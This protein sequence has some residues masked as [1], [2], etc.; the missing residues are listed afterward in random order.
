M[1]PRI[2]ECSAT[3]D[4]ITIVFTEVIANRQ[5]T[6]FEL[7]S[8]VGTTVDVSGTAWGD[9]TV[10]ITPGSSLTPGDWLFVK[11][12]FP[13][14]VEAEFFTRVNG[15]ES[16]LVDIA[17]SAGTA[18]KAV[19]SIASY[20]L[21]TTEMGVS[22][23]AP[24]A[25]TGAPPGAPLQRVVDDA[26]RTVLGRLPKVND[27]RSVAAALTQSF[28][29]R[30]EGGRT[31]WEWT[32]KSYVGQTDL[33]GG[34]TGAQAS[35]AA[36]AK[37]ALDNSLP[38]L[39]G[40]SP[41]DSHA[42]PQE[43][44]AA[45]A[46]LRTQWIGFANELANEGGPRAARANDL[47][48]NAQESV[49]KLGDHL[50]MRTFNEVTQKR[51]ITRKNVVTLE[52]EK[53][54]TNF[55]AVSDYVYSVGRSWDNYKDHFFQEDLGTGLVLLQRALLAV[56][57]SVGELYAAMD[58]VFVGP[59]ERLTARIDVQDPKGMV[60]EELLSWISSFASTEAT[61]LIRDGGKRGV[62][63]IKPTVE[64]LRDL[65]DQFRASLEKTQT[66]RP[67]GLRHSRVRKL[68]QE[69][70]SHLTEVLNRAKK[71]TPP[72]EVVRQSPSQGPTTAA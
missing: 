10:T 56:A 63:A 1:P 3:P 14:G 57:E 6:A 38:L 35:L 21:L 70:S 36:F 37:S 19:E 66:G 50:G 4:A 64:S 43:V 67:D 12:T 5:R 26:L 49:N 18:S 23:G 22:A 42:D 9:R 24:R 7:Q 45:R 39:D 59:A 34:V 69:L 62:E 61:E 58:S 46:I 52:E 55:M 2:A 29:S 17:A 32:P 33:G 25:V 65:V 11:A 30:E 54:L 41:L 53:N 27:A 8:P 71:V 13:S 20:P 40:L 60:V 51:E 31:V 47:S 15:D 72:E 68:L 44:E 16:T 48:K 28:S